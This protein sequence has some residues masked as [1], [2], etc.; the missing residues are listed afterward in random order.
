MPGAAKR[1]Q[2]KLRAEK[3]ENVK[4]GEEARTRAEDD[5]SDVSDNVLKC[6]EI[7]EIFAAVADSVSELSM[8][9]ETNSVKSEEVSEKICMLYQWG[10][11][12]YMGKI[13]RKGK[14]EKLPLLKTTFKSR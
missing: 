11:C 4:T 3:T 2:K 13:C 10:K 12:K 5:K 9:D 1:R 7:D 6:E 14:H 8:T